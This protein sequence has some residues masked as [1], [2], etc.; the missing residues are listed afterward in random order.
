MLMVSVGEQQIACGK[1]EFKV[2]SHRRSRTTARRTMA[3]G[4]AAI[5]SSVHIARLAV[6]HLAHIVMHIHDRVIHRRVIHFS[7]R[8]I[9]VMVHTDWRNVHHL[10]WHRHS[11]Q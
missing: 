3:N 4:F 9:H 1:V 7:H 11:R 5:V 2:I 8:M 6:V 10:A